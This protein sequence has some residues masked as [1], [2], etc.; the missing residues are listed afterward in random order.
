[1]YYQFNSTAEIQSDDRKWAAI[2]LVLISCVGGG[3]N[4]YIA[5]GFMFGIRFRG[6]FFIFSVSKTCSNILTSSLVFFWMVPAVFA[7]SNL[8]TDHF[9]I[10]LSQLLLF[11]LYIQGNLTQ[12]FLSVNRFATICFMG[13]NKRKNTD[14]ISLGIFSSWFAT[15]LWT[16]MGY[17]ECTCSFSTQSLTFQFHDEC[18]V[19][20]YQLQVY[21]AFVL[22]MVANM[23]NTISFLII[24]CGG[25]V[26]D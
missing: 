17:P 1:M 15:I 16:L 10:I 7:N 21:C 24:I 8:V 12:C 6:G 23:L 18:H 14:L 20:N 2:L 9:N 22:M 4:A 26:S 13:G 5:S 25:A 11:G 3:I 19:A